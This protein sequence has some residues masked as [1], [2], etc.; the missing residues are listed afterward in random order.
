M[1]VYRSTQRVYNTNADI[2]LNKRAEFQAIIDLHKPDI[3]GITEVLPKN[4]R[5][6]RSE[7]ELE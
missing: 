6:E 5:F 7:C 1:M 3:I 2:F 4:G